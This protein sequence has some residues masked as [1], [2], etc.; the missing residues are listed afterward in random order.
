MT[1]AWTLSHWA[2]MLG[3]VLLAALSAWLQNGGPDVRI[4]DVPVLALVL[5]VL[6][7]LYQTPPRRA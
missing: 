4:G 2:T 6:R 3:A 1:R 5:L 7:A